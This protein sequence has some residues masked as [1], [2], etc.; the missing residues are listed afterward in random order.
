MPD[1]VFRKGNTSAV[2]CQINPA[3][4]GIFSTLAGYGPQFAVGAMILSFVV[5]IV[6]S[7]ISKSAGADTNKEFYTETGI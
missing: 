2:E 6:V 7:I 5:C 3:D 1:G 4:T